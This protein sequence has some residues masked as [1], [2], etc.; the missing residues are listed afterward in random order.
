MCYEGRRSGKACWVEDRHESIKLHCAAPSGEEGRGLIRGVSGR[1]RNPA[2]NGLELD[3]RAVGRDGSE[4]GWKKAL[5][6]TC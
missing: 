5:R 2:A 1:R 3:R 4:G 6:G